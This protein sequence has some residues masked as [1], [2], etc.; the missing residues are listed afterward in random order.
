MSHRMTIHEKVV[1]RQVFKQLSRKPIMCICKNKGADHRAFSLYKTGSGFRY[2]IFPNWL[3][4]FPIDL[5]HSQLA[6]KSQFKRLIFPILLKIALFF[7]PKMVIF[8]PKSHNFFPI[9][10]VPKI[11]QKGQKKPWISF[12]ATAKLISTFVFATWTV[13]FILVLSKAKISSLK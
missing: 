4:K 1:P 11:S 12:A 8:S 3:K 5:K 9:S 6:E 7:F 2:Q 10:L 13:Q